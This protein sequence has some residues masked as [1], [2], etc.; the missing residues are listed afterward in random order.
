MPLVTELAAD[1][2]DETS[3]FA[4]VLWARAA[5]TLR[6]RGAWRRAAGQAGP[7]IDAQTGEVAAR[8]RLLIAEGALAIHDRQAGDL[9][10]AAEHAAQAFPLYVWWGS[11][12]R[13]RLERRPAPGI[14]ELAQNLDDAE[15]KSLSAR[16]RR[17]GR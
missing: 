4:C 6:D 9:I 7:R 11:C 2:S 5:A 13:A 3:A 10:D 17:V 14:G 1:A 15:L 16:A 8:L 12:L